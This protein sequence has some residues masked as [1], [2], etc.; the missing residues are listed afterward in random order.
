MFRG[1][2]G[3]LGLDVWMCS[4]AWLCGSCYRRLVVT[5]F[6]G[7][8]I[9]NNSDCFREYL[10]HTRYSSVSTMQKSKRKYFSEMYVYYL[11]SGVTYK[12]I[13]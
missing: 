6:C 4:G 7:K 1:I 13:N 5:A 10:Y 12:K 8:K 11:I 9:V 2:Y 3:M